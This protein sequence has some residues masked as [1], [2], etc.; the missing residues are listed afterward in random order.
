[1]KIQN[2]NNKIVASILVSLL[3]FSSLILFSGSIISNVNAS[4]N[5]TANITNDYGNLL[6]YEWPQ[7]HGDPGFTRFSAGP[8]PEASDILW[9]TTVNDIQSY[10]TAFNGKVLVTTST[11]VIALDKD[12]GNVLWNITLPDIQR[13]PA[14]FKID[15]THLVISNYCL[16]IETGKILW[17]SNEFSAKVSYW[18]ES[19]YSPQEELFYVQGD[20]VVQAW[21]FSN[22]AEPP[23]IEWETYV[24]GSI[25]SGTGI[26]YGEGRVFP[27]SFEPHQVALNGSTGEI[28]WDTETTGAMSFSGS[29]YKGK[30]LKAG[31][32]DNVF[33]C[34]DAETGEI[35]W[36]YNPG[37]Q[38][39]Y[40][41]SGS[42][43]AYDMVYELNKDG[44]LYA[45]D[46]NSG[47]LVWK[48]EGPGYLFW[49]GW[50]VVADGKVYATTG[51][52]VSYD[53][54]TL[55]YST[56]EFAC[57]DAFTGDL[58]WKLPL[59]THC[60]RDSIAIAYGNLYII[61][62]YIEE[63]TM[64]DYITLDEVWAIG[65]D[66]WSMWRKDSGNNGAGQT[67]PT[68]LNLRWKFTTGGGIVS[69]PVAVDGKVYVGSQDK[70]IYCIDARNGRFIWSFMTGARIK[71]SPAVVNGKVYIG[72]EDGYVYCL[73]AN[74]GSLI[75]K[76][77]AGGY[78]E[79]HF[80]A[81]TGIRSSPI[82]VGDRVYVGSLDTKLYCLDANSGDI[83]WTY[84]TDGY[85]T[86]S[87]AVSAGNV[88]IT[89]QEPDT[90][91][92]YKLDADDGSLVWKLEIEYV[93]V[94]DRGKDLHVSPTV[95]DG[96][97]FVASNKD[98]YHGVN[99]TTGEIEWSYL[100]SRGTE[101]I[102]G[103]LVASPTY[104]D[105]HLYVVDMFFITALNASNGEVVWKSWLGTELYTTPTYA[106]DKLYVTTDR[107]FTYALNATN[108]IR[109]SYYETASNSWSSPSVFEGR[110]Y[111]GN[112]DNNVY[113]LTNYPV[114]QG[115]I[116][117][118]L[119]KYEVEVN[120][121][122]TGCGQLAPGI[123]YAPVTVV[124]AKSDGISEFLQVTAQSNGAFSFSYTPNMVGDWK[125]SIR[126]SGSAYILNNADISL[127]VIESQ[128]QTTVPDQTT[129]GND[130]PT[131][132]QNL[133]IPVEYVIAA[134]VIVIIATIG[135][136]VFLGA[137]KRN[138][139]SQVL[140]SSG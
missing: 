101:G 102:G 89:S 6:Q 2:R 48:Y 60:P 98:F 63:M 87:P 21:N 56:S 134:V 11:N 111:F 46:V 7:I 3:I 59:E 27:G 83:V 126:C 15:E 19:V 18:A 43:V 76:T 119:D 49:P 97:V 57:L 41:I 103:Y 17:T 12:K 112:N 10:V 123:A 14:I 117:A 116:S 78:I 1:M 79:A 47:Q 132:E 113:C 28:L 93:I 67:G 138:K 69:T 128:Q 86:A 107:R 13:W 36:R 70:K 42:A 140:I 4:G 85:I 38:L 66:S 23:T 50:P 16:E 73:N 9:K 75:W 125:V 92:L 120:G 100:T 54:Y 31:E 26:Q 44:N 110:L 135:V 71:S 30:L 136:V 108:G 124:W 80:K 96:M 137:K 35:L 127:K 118:Q 90:G 122:I 5:P 39:G 129:N 25:S 34:F 106:D 61:P 55:E 45:L 109:L 32:Q 114:T 22:P 58:V 131:D 130:Q 115:Q 94:A 121:T 84:K 72:P 20:S 95:G 40:W 33:Y 65:T 52:R 82:V 24:S 105:G 8:A 62:G 29:Y 133:V 64:D 53:P 88:Y 77:A 139:S 68:E 74:N 51:Q 91:A 104:H 81:V 99:T 37:T